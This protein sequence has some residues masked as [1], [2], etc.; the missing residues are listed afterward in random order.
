MCSG[1]AHGPVISCP[2]ILRGQNTGVISKDS[3]SV[4]GSKSQLKSSSSTLICTEVVQICPYDCSCRIS[5]EVSCGKRALVSVFISVFG[6]FNFL[7][8]TA[9][10][11][12]APRTRT[13]QTPFPLGLH[14]RLL[15]TYR[16]GSFPAPGDTKKYPKWH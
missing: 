12:Q 5:M 4:K 7:R 8:T 13:A 11:K 14:I 10:C 2:E 3:W 16:N 6:R 15:H 9:T 1:L